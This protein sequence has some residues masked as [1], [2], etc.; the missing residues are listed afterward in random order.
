M[1]RP[2][3]V[4]RHLGA[5]TRTVTR[6][7]RDGKPARVVIAVR[8]FPS[9]PD[10][11][12]DAITSV[13]RI[14][15][16]FLPVAGDL[17]LG[18]RFQLEGNAGGRILV[19]DRPRHLGLTWEGGGQTS[20]VDVRL[21]SLKPE[22]TRLELEHVAHVPDELWDQFGPGA[23]GVGWESGLMGLAE[24]L[25]GT[26]AVTPAEGMA[27][28]GTDEGRRFLRGSSDAWRDAS[29]RHGTLAEAARAAAERTYA[30]YTGTGE[31]AD[32]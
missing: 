9:D 4:A 3:D 22:R 18:G 32:S 6:T 24:Y 13:E 15:R 7:D 30:A 25:S 23:V 11:V 20:W 31:A 19:C 21:T 2:V 29:I 10:D 17:R 5:V 8:E 16:W 28:L 1:T 14:P 26:P 12:W 27:W